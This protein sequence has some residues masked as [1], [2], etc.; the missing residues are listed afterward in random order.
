LISQS[1]AFIYAPDGGGAKS[2]RDAIWADAPEPFG[3][4]LR[5]AAAHDEKVVGLSTLEGIVLRYGMFY[6]PGLDP[7]P[8]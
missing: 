2:E 6:G 4:A 5:T 1:V 8:A 3:G 7:A